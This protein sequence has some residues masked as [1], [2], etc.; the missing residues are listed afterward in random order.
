LK[1]DG[2]MR[3][4][5]SDP[6]IPA[7]FE[8]KLLYIGPIYRTLEWMRLL[9]TSQFHFRFSRVEVNQNLVFSSNQMTEGGW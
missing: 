7:L 1:T 9:A 6:A 5:A 8:I 2:S 4:A 3:R